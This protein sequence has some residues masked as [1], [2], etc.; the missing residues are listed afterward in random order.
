[1]LWNTNSSFKFLLKEEDVPLDLE[2]EG[3]ID[4]PLGGKIVVAEVY[5]SGLADKN[6]MWSSICI[7]KLEKTFSKRFTTFSK[8]MIHYELQQ[9]EV[10]CV[11]K[12]L[13]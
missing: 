7:S 10:T 3:G 9:W 11:H 6:G 8:Y 5:H 13:H 1:M 12:S 2:I 4:S